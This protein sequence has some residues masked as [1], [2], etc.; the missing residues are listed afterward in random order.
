[1]IWYQDILARAHV[2]LELDSHLLGLVAAGLRE[3]SVNHWSPC[4]IHCSG[5]SYCP[6]MLVVEFLNISKF[7]DASNC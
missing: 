2:L 5:I 6:L 3:S 4:S 7:F 1:M